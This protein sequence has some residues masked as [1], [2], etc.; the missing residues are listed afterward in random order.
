MNGADPMGHGPL[1]DRTETTVDRRALVVVVTALAVIAIAQAA[2]PIGSPP[3]YD[4]VV[5]EEPYRFVSPGPD[6][7]GDPT[8]FTGTSAPQNGKSPA[9]AAATS[10][11]PPQAQI[12]AA[13]GALQPAST[14]GPMTIAI[15]PL[16]PQPQDDVVGNAYRI[17]VTDAAG[18]LVPISAGAH[19]SLVLRAPAGAVDVRVVQLTNDTWHELPTQPG[20]AQADVYTTNITAFGVFAVTSAGATGIGLDPRLVLFGGLLALGS[21]IVLLA[22]FLGSGGTRGR[23][24]TPAAPAPLPGVRNRRRRKRR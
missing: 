21:V 4:G 3:L 18:G 1:P 13:S 9:I 10:E 20:G 22:L 6:E 2:A 5:V 8:S 11:S 23:R 7:T 15:E 24:P 17:S 16:V 12:I 14:A 19:V